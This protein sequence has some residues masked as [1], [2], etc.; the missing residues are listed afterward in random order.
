M[1]SL[2]RYSRRSQLIR[3]ISV[4]S[5]EAGGSWW[6]PSRSETRASLSN[7]ST[8]SLATRTRRNV[9]LTSDYRQCLH[10]VSQ[11]IGRR[12]DRSTHQLCRGH[13]SRATIW[14]TQVCYH[15]PVLLPFHARGRC[16]CVCW[17]YDIERRPGAAAPL[18]P[19]ALI[20]YG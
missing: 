16:V 9:P 6:C 3:F 12:I 15:S 14:R 19:L 10:G 7:I 13:T 8:S 2:L 4:R 20:A 11:D 17:A 18:I 5:G 1:S